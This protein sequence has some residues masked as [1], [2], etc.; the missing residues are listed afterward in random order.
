MA[1]QVANTAWIALGA[2]L[3]E[4]R[5]TL[6]WA[7]Q[8]LAKLGTVTGVSALYRTAPMGGP[9]GQPDYLNAA[10]SLRTRLSAPD[11]LAALHNLET[12]AGRERRERWEARILDLD[13]ILYGEL[14]IDTPALTLPHPRAW[15]RA[16]VLAP[17]ADLDPLRRHPE[18][19]ESVR[20]AL[21]RISVDGILKETSDW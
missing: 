1:V 18:T 12:R 10:L 21:D 19:G 11:L 20:A 16:F 13:L 5:T 7:R 3:G 2:N 4:P 17:L 14:V 8:E 15:Q 6:Q 9:R